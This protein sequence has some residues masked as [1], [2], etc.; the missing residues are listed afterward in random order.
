MQIFVRWIGPLSICLWLLISCNSTEPPVPPGPRGPLIGDIQILYDTVGGIPIVL[1]G[2]GVTNLVVSYERKLQNGQLLDFTP[3][4]HALPVLMEDQLGNQWDVFGYATEGPNAGDR[5]TVTDAYMGYW[6]SFGAMFPGAWISGADS[7]GPPISPPVLSPGWTIPRSS[8]FA[9][10][11]QDVIPALNSPTFI[12]YKGRDFIDTPFYLDDEDLVVGVR[13]GETI[14]LYPHAIL[15][16]HEIVNDEIEGQKI[17]VIYCP[18]TGTATAW[19]RTLNGTETQFGVSGLL[20]NNNVIPFDRLT[21]SRWSQLSGE[22]VNGAL[23]G[24]KA[25]AFPVVETTWGTWK[26][27]Y[28]LP[29][30]LSDKTGHN[31]DYTV[32][33]YG[34]YRTDDQSLSFPLVYDDPRLR[35]KER[36]HAIVVDG[37]AKV[38]RLGM[39]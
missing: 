13:I 16:W 11:G 39:F 24:Q 21:N 12:H 6:F 9:G 4:Q 29:E 15:D 31:W 34:D 18:F 35:R 37:Q 22:C 14:R 5:L 30:I 25:I 19:A 2:S 23:I 32:Y 33:P 27:M 3:V 1:V 28:N 7:I 10:T 20:Y 17:A 36:V 8:V 38:Y 26:M